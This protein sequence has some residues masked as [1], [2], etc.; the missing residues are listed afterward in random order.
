[1]EYNLPFRV[2]HIYRLCQI[3]MFGVQPTH[4]CLPTVISILATTISFTKGKLTSLLEILTME[5]LANSFV[6]KYTK[7]SNFHQNPKIWNQE[8]FKAPNQEDFKEMN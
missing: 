3:V 2:S 6:S 8:S 5:N 7:M 4:M 1:M